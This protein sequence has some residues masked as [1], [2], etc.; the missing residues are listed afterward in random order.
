MQPRRRHWLCVTKAADSLTDDE[1]VVPTPHA[2]VRLSVCSSVYKCVW[3]GEPARSHA[4][5]SH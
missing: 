4:V 1:D 3:N 2:T 5:N